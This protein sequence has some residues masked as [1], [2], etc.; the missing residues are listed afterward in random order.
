MPGAASA[1]SAF[2]SRLCRPRQARRYSQP[3]SRPNSTRVPTLSSRLS[4]GAPDWNG[5]NSLS[6]GMTYSADALNRLPSPKNRPATAD[7]PGPKR[8]AAM[9]MGM[10]AVVAEMGGM[11]I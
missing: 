8:Q 7:S 2:Q 4:S 5:E 1:S 3:M 11:W 9:T 10:N 6:L